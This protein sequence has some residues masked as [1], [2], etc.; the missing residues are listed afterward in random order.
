[1]AFGFFVRFSL[2]VTAL[3]ARTVVGKPVALSPAKSP[4]DAQSGC[5]WE[6]NVVG[7]E[8]GLGAHLRIQAYYIAS[9]VRAA[10]EKE[11][12]KPNRCE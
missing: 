10:S 9:E 12:F 1:M 6:C 11:V 7:S 4:R 3:F 5:I 2:F 8:F